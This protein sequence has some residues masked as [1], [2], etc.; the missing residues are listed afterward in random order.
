MKETLWVPSSVETTHLFQFI[1]RVNSTYTL[2][3]K[4]YQDLY[5]W[6]I[7][8]LEYFWKEVWD[9]TAIK[10]TQNYSSVILNQAS[11]LETTW[12]EGAQ[13]NFADNCLKKR[14]QSIAISALSEG[15]TF[16]QLTYEELYE[17][18]S[19]VSA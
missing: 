5:H 7:T 18:V 17:K 16:S 14:D 12:F 3:L 9:F 4:T 6:S 10:Y 8:Q 1:Q 19:K 11:M 2:S 13:L 15:H